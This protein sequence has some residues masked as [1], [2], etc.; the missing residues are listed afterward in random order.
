MPSA[1]HLQHV[2]DQRHPDHVRQGG[3]GLRRI[4]RRQDRPTFESE[5]DH[6]VQDHETGRQIDFGRIAA[7]FGRNQKHLPASFASF[8]LSRTRRLQANDF[9][10]DSIERGEGQES[11]DPLSADS[12]EGA[13]GRTVV[14][15]EGARVANQS[16]TGITTGS[17][18]V[19]HRIGTEFT[20][21]ERGGHQT[22]DDHRWLQPPK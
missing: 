18:K 5:K 11:A 20:V 13:H 22:V 6:R 1:D 2:H 3:P 4:V 10:E 19:D 7:V 8:R 9:V 12:I 17:E 14:D 15:R 16:R 21:D